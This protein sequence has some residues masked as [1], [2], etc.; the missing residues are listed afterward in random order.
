[1]TK[2]RFYGRMFM[3]LHL[4]VW[5][6]LKTALRPWLTPETAWVALLVAAYLWSMVNTL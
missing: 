1:M 2:I 4:R 6:G 3:R 5:V